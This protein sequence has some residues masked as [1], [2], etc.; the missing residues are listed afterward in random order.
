MSLPNAEKLIADYLREL[1]AVP[2]VV[3]KTPQDQ[4]TG[5]VRLTKLSAPSQTEPLD[6][7]IRYMIQL[8]CYAGAGTPEEPDALG[9]TGGRP[10]ATELASV[11]RAAMKEMPGNLTGAVCTGT[12]C[13]GDASNP[14][15]VF[16]EDRERVILTFYA[17]IHPLPAAVS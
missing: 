8:D 3:N 9:N 6:W 10:E 15:E 5:W 11:V 12:Q 17:W 16:A 13:I 4:S 14:D 1:D 2:R 7:L